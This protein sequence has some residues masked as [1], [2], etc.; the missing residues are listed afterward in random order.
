L[1]PGKIPEDFD[2]AVIHHIHSFIVPVDVTEN[3][4]QAI[5]IVFLIEPSLVFVVIFDAP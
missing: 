3:R 4:L 5:A 2:K 1:K